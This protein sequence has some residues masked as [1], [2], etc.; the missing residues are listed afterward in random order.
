VIVCF[1]YFLCLPDDALPPTSSSSSPASRST[2]ASGHRGEDAL[3]PSC[4]R[5]GHRAEAERPALRAAA[6]PLVMSAI[7]PGWDAISCRCR[8]IQQH[9]RA[10]RLAYPL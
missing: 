3:L 2:S 4:G 1:P 7:E 9:A 8:R 6:P 5:H 10:A